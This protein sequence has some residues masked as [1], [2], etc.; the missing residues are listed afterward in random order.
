MESR[1][2]K[3][4]PGNFVQDG[5]SQALSSAAGGGAGGSDDSDPPAA[6]LIPVCIVLAIAS[7][8]CWV[9]KQK[10]GKEVSIFDAFDAFDPQDN[11][12][13]SDGA[14]SSGRRATTNNAPAPALDACVTDSAPNEIPSSR[15]KNNGPILGGPWENL[16]LVRKTKRAT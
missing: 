8:A 11:P 12:A 7:I 15:T 9:Y 16:L 10:T 3:P 13:S 14:A 4:K 1:G 5:A 6:L 2:T